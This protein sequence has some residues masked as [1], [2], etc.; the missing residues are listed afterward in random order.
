M[1]IMIII[2]KTLIIMIIGARAAG[3]PSKVEV[4][5]HVV[6]LRN[7]ALPDDRGILNPLIGKWLDG[8]TH[9]S[10]CPFMPSLT[11]TQLLTQGHREVHAVLGMF[12]AARQRD[13]QP[14][15]ICIHLCSR[16]QP[17]HEA[18][19][20]IGGCAAAARKS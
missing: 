11:A 7:A 10:S 8:C 20:A 3:F 19:A 15:A 6:T 1:M 14:S 18:N 9:P 13:M 12:K 2:S 4:E 5:A 16:A 17:G